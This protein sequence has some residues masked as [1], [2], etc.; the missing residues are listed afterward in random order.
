MNLIFQKGVCGNVS[1]F[2]PLYCILKMYF[3]FLKKCSYV[4]I[5]FYFN[6]LGQFKFCRL[7]WLD[8]LRGIWYSGDYQLRFQS[9]FNKYCQSNTHTLNVG[10]HTYILTQKYRIRTGDRAWGE[11]KNMLPLN[12]FVLIWFGLCQCLPK[13]PFLARLLGSHNSYHLTPVLF[14]YSFGNCKCNSNVERS[15]VREFTDFKYC[16]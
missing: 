9:S 3:N 7:G 6:N 10:K 12:G 5:N 8:C 1:I 4:Y 15:R 14:L 11:S 16:S 2:Y 13:E